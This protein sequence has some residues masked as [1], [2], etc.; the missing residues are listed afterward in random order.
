MSS[1]HPLQLDR[2]STPFTSSISA[3]RSLSEIHEHLRMS[4][5]SPDAV[6]PSDP[7]PVPFHS[8]P[9]TATRVTNSVAGTTW[10]HSLTSSFILHADLYLG[11][12][13]PLHPIQT[14]RGSRKGF[15]SR[16]LAL[17]CLLLSLRFSRTHAISRLRKSRTT[18]TYVRSFALS[19]TVMTQLSPYS[20]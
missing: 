15:R 12:T 10:N 19:G 20:H 16:K 18:N 8:L 9:S 4:H 2:R 7:S 13:P 1:S 6:L 17:L 11:L 3:L 14:F 5:F